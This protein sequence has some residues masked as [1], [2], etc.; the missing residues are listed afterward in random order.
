MTVD[1]HLQPEALFSAM[2]FT[3]VKNMKALTDMIKKGEINA[4]LI[5]PSMILDMFHVK[6]AVNKSKR[7]ELNKKMVTRG[8]FG[9]IIYNLSPYRKISEAFGAYGIN[10]NDTSLLAIL[11]D[12]ESGAIKSDLLN[13]IEGDEVDLSLLSQFSNHSEIA[14]FFKLDNYQSHEHLSKFVSSSIACKALL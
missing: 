14:K 1:M 12:D 11:L 5:K 9:E 8:I 3:N 2:L 13:K 10:A 4:A 7:A 6:V